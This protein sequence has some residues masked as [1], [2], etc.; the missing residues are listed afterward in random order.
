[1]IYLYSYLIIGVLLLPLTSKHYYI[2]SGIMNGVNFGI[3]DYSI[4]L[5]FIPFWVLGISELIKGIDKSYYD[6]SK[7]F[8]KY[9]IKE[10]FQL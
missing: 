7:N 4:I 9:T 1:M 5:L 2:N 6:R 3:K 10:L 8:K